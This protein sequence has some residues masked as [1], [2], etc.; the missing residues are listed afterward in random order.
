MVRSLKAFV[1]EALAVNRMSSSC[2]NFF[3]TFISAEHAQFVALGHAE[4]ARFEGPFPQ[5]LQFYLHSIACTRSCY[6]RIGTICVS[7]PFLILNIDNLCLLSSWSDL[8]EIIH[9]Y[10]SFPRT[11]VCLSGCSLFL[12]S[13]PPVSALFLSSSRSFSLHLLVS[14]GGCLDCWLQVFSVFPS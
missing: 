7:P 4:H 3:P 10:R 12:P 2:P 11:S 13:V 5:S 9:S 1:Q 6:F 14:G 8:L